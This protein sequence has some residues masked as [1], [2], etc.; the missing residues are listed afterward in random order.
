M[1]R[2]PHFPHPEYDIEE[3][4]EALTYQLRGQQSE[5][6]EI[7][8]AEMDKL[9]R[10]GVLELRPDRETMSYGVLTPEDLVRAYYY[11][12]PPEPTPEPP[13]KKPP[14]KIHKKLRIESYSVKDKARERPLKIP[15]KKAGFH[16][17]ARIERENDVNSSDFPS[18]GYVSVQKVA[19][20]LAVSKS[21]LQRWKMRPDFP[22]PV[23]MGERRVMFDAA[24]TLAWSKKQ[25][26]NR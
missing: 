21:T 1:I 7:T 11:Y 5:H 6:F 25:A 24:E 10:F 20:F 12:L 17:E 19:D 16:E 23:K 18:Q 4:R 2:K 14:L 26:K 9:F 8:S 3:A 15:S 13:A 22:K